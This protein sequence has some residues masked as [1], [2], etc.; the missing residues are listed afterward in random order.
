M[1][2]STV[3]VFQL[4]NMFEL[5]LPEHVDR[6]LGGLRLTTCPLDQ[7]EPSKWLAEV[8]NASLREREMPSVLPLLKKTFL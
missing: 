3:S 6:L 8:V 2:V 7:K 1:D 4:M 5:L